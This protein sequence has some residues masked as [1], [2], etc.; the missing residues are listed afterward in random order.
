[1]EEFGYS[2]HASHQAIS[3]QYQTSMSVI[4]SWITYGAS[5]KHQTQRP[6]SEVVK[7]SGFRENRSFRKR[8]N[9]D[10]GKFIAPLYQSPNESISLA[11]L[12]LRMRDTYSYLPHTWKLEKIAN[13]GNPRTGEIILNQFSLTTPPLFQLVNGLY[14]RYKTPQQTQT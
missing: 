14:D 9:Y 4:F 5:R 11:D 1:M 7:N 10:P 3:K 6:Y 8:F 13:E 12:A 2:R